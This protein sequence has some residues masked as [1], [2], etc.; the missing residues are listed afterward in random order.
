MPIDVQNSLAHMRGQFISIEGKDYKCDEQGII[1]GM[2]EADAKKLVERRNSPWR[3][4]TERKPVAKAP[5]PVAPVA[6]VASPSPLIPPVEHVPE[7]PKVPEVKVEA[8]PEVPAP[9][10][11][12]KIPAPGEDWP[13]P[14]EKMSLGYLQKMAQAYNVKFNKTMSKAVLTKKI[15]A[16]MYG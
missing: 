14:D 7:V 16:A 9:S 5:G 13:D 12:E 11:A 4:Y 15:M 2:P 8:K 6:P 1:R 10:E 3:Y